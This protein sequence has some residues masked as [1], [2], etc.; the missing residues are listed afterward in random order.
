VATEQLRAV[1]DET[2]YRQRSR[3]IPLRRL[4]EPSEAADAIAFL[5]SP[6]ARYITGQLLVL[7]GGASAVGCYSYETYKRAE[8]Q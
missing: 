5:A 3:A 1:Y 4:A 2:M 7:D 6:Q 8:P